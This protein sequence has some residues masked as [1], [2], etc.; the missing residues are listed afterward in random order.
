MTILLAILGLILGIQVMMRL[1]HPLYCRW[2]A[3]AVETR[4]AIP[5]LDYLSG[6]PVTSTH[7]ITIDA[8]SFE[9]WPWLVQMG[10]G[11]GGCYSYTWLENLVGCR[12]ENADRILPQFQHLKEGD[13]IMLHPK[14]P[15]L[16]V[17][18]LDEDRVLALEGWVFYLQPLGR[19]QTRLLTRT[20]AVP[21]KKEVGVAGR[22]VD[23]VTRTVWFDLAHYIMGRKQLIELKRLVEHAALR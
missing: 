10:S 8:P 12:M 18:R 15:P 14:A 3:T 11:R 19:N 6:V 23:F 1:L 9:I 2:G 17:T 5:G 16:V 21:P 22:L 7:A 13:G 20:Y 4:L